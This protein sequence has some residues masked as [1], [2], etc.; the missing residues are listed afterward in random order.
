MPNDYINHYLDEYMAERDEL[1]SR[2]FKRNS[3]LFNKEY[4]EHF[5][6]MGKELNERGLITSHGGNLSITDGEFIWVTRTGSNLGHLHPEDVIMIPWNPEENEEDVSSDM[7]IHYAMYAGGVELAERTGEKFETMAIVHVHSPHVIFRSL[8]SDEILSVDSESRSV[9]GPS[10]PVIEAAHGLHDQA[11]ERVF[12]HVVAEG[13]HV[14]VIKGHGTFAA[15]KTMYEAHRYV[16][17]LEMTAKL[18]DLYDATGRTF[19]PAIWD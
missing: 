9:L 8:I 13:G 17:S 4:L 1:T 16:S 3:P 15:G 10:T 5:I 6:H 11:M 7:H 12:K 2:L 14:V 18:L 19:D